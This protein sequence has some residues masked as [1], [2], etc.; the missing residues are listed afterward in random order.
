ML[1]E[2]LFFGD[3]DQVRQL[4]GPASDTSEQRLLFY[5]AFKFPLLLQIPQTGEL[6]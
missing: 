1:A 6:L 5:L 2:F 3:C 4:V